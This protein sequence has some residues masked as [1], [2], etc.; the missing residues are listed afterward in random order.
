MAKDVQQ[1]IEE[2]AERY[3]GDGT[4]NRPAIPPAVASWTRLWIDRTQETPEYTD[5]ALQYRADLKDL[6]PDSNVRKKRIARNNKRT[7]QDA[8]K[9]L[10]PLCLRSTQQAASMFYPPQMSFLWEHAPMV[11]DDK[12][13]APVVP[14]ERKQ[15]AKAMTNE[16][17]RVLDAVEWRS[18][19]F[20]WT[21]AAVRYSMG[22]LKVQWQED[23]LDEPVAKSRLPDTQDNKARLEHIAREIIDG[24]TAID[25]GQ[26]NEMLRIARMLDSGA[27]DLKRWT[28]VR[29]ETVPVD[30]IRL[31]PQ[32]QSPDQ[33]YSGRWMCELIPMSGQQI[34]DKFPFR[35]TGPG[36][37]TWIDDTSCLSW[38]GVHPDDLTPTDG[39]D[40]TSTRIL[41]EE[42]DRTRRAL[43][44]NNTG[45]GNNGGAPG[46]SASASGEDDLYLLYQVYD[47]MSERVICMLPGVDYPIATFK[48]KN[49]TSQFFPFV[50]IVLNP[51]EETPYGSGDIELTADEQAR[52]NLKR[53]DDERAR[54][55]AGTKIIYNSALIDQ[56]KIEMI[57]RAQSGQM[58]GINLGGQ[59]MA[60]AMM[61][62]EYPYKPENYDTTKDMQEF[63]RAS[64]LP[65]NLLG[66]VGEAAFATEANI[67]A[68]GANILTKQRQRIMNDAFKRALNMVAEMI[69]Q[70][71]SPQEVRDRQGPH[72]V[73]P[74]I[75]TDKEAA[76]LVRQAQVQA[77]QQVMTSLAEGD[78][79]GADDLQAEVSKAY[80]AIAMDKWG[81][82][83]PLTRES[84]YK[85]LQVNV[86]VNVNELLENQQL[87]ANVVQL[88]QT[89][90]TS[91]QAFNRKALAHI[92]AKFLKLDDE[93]DSILDMDPNVLTQE[94]AI[95]MGEAGQKATLDTLQALAAIGATAGQQLEQLAAREQAAAT[96]AEA[97][98][99]GA[100][101]EE[102]DE[103]VSAAD[104]DSAEE[105][106]A[107]LARAR[108]TARGQVDTSQRR[109]APATGGGLLG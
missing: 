99:Q 15:F 14:R 46:N 37:G 51:E 60:Q 82:M 24:T 47:R 74:E 72:S 27:S 19:W 89:M 78:G 49:P 61:P 5:R 7:E 66:G 45:S 87:A 107:E 90:L 20:R 69:L 58:V 56:P 33:I 57:S 67:A 29:M 52:I 6:H 92:L 96:I 2:T 75:H 53:S 31:D 97:E 50:F 63:Q 54:K 16:V 48:V 106:N 83:V 101:L 26:A 59:D 4:P 95:A 10:T 64:G 23:F 17:L 12:D 44:T 38:T 73:W 11:T 32:V 34:L 1:Q 98:A 9:V 36:E 3:G 43:G 62:W 70:G 21:L 80:G 68:Q 65:E 84:L 86:R 104:A 77:I 25:E 22:I 100:S 102:L 28:G 41:Q 85:S 55:M 103:S 93:I 76:E 13:Q 35:E 81:R 108:D 8:R 79:K 30:R 42:R 39:D 88:I 94:L 71:F 18:V 109:P 91:G 40:P 105:A